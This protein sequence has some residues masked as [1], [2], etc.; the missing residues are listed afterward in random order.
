VREALG[1]VL[2]SLVL[3][4]TL[5]LIAYYNDNSEALQRAMSNSIHYRA[6]STGAIASDSWSSGLTANFEAQELTLVTGLAYVLDPSEPWNVTLV[7]LISGQAVSLPSWYS[8]WSSYSAQSTLPDGGLTAIT[9]NGFTVYSN[10]QPTPN[11][12]LL[13]PGERISVPYMGGFVSV[14]TD[15]GNYWYPYSPAQGYRDSTPAVGGLEGLLLNSSVGPGVPQVGTPKWPV[16]VVPVG[17]ALFEVWSS[18]TIGG[19]GQLPSNLIQGQPSWVGGLPNDTFVTISVTET[20]FHNYN[21]TGVSGSFE[22]VKPIFANVSNM[23]F[24]VHVTNPVTVYLHLSPVNLGSNAHGEINTKDGGVR[25]EIPRSQDFTPQV[26]YEAGVDEL[27]FDVGDNYPPPIAISPI[28]FQYSRFDGV[29]YNWRA[30]YQQE[31][32]ND[33]YVSPALVLGWPSPP[34]WVYYFPPPPTLWGFQFFGFVYLQAGGYGEFGIPEYA[35]AV[36]VGVIVIPVLFGT[37]VVPVVSPVAYFRLVLFNLNVPYSYTYNEVTFRDGVVGSELNAEF[38]AGTPLMS[39]AWYAIK[40]QGGGSGGGFVFYTTYLQRLEEDYVSH[41]SPPSPPS[42]Y[43]DLVTALPPPWHMGN[44]TQFQVPFYAGMD[45]SLSDYLWP[46]DSLRVSSTGGVLLVNASSPYLPHPSLTVVEPGGSEDLIVPYGTRVSVAANT[47]TRNVSYAGAQASGGVRLEDESPVTN[48]EFRDGLVRAQ[49]NGGGELAVE[50]NGSASFNVTVVSSPG[51]FVGIADGGKSY[52]VYLGA[53]L[54]FPANTVLFLQGYPSFPG[55]VFSNWSGEVWTLS[56]GFYRVAELLPN[57]SVEEVS[58]A[59]L[60]EDSPVGAFALIGDT[61]VTAN[62]VDPARNWTVVGVNVRSPGGGVLYSTTFNGGPAA[63]TSQFNFS[64]GYYPYQEYSDSFSSLLPPTTGLTVGLGPSSMQVTVLG[65]GVNGTFGGEAGAILESYSYLGGKGNFIYGSSSA[66]MGYVL[67][68][69]PGEW[70]VV[71]GQAGVPAFSYAYGYGISRYLNLPGEVQRDLGQY[72]A[73]EASA[74][75]F[76]GDLIASS[77]RGENEVASHYLGSLLLSEV[78]YSWVYAGYGSGNTQ[79]DPVVLDWELGMGLLVTLSSA[80]WGIASDLI[81][82]QWDV[83]NPW[84]SNWS[85]ALLTSMSAQRYYAELTLNVYASVEDFDLISALLNSTSSNYGVPAPVVKSL[86]LEKSNGI[87]V[88]LPSYGSAFAWQGK[89]V[90]SGMVMAYYWLTDWL[91]SAGYPSLSSGAGGLASYG[92]V[93]ANL[94]L[95]NSI[96]AGAQSAGLMWSVSTSYYYTPGLA[97]TWFQGADY[98]P[99]S[100]SSAPLYIQV[101]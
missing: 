52:Y 20:G 83:V 36:A 75:G 64:L 60:P 79:L 74:H 98:S 92:D 28:P 54:Q 82:Y 4:A 50:F 24:D 95:V 31:W 49:V 73:Y 17:P 14:M 26:L 53:T 78:A 3:T 97:L 86:L 81:G 69:R 44:V 85:D 16:A 66:V 11:G 57:G 15:G 6:K 76:L 88:D 46:L 12:V 87:T 47:F 101:S 68:T 93:T 59:A 94:E 42:S 99:S 30:F 41:V 1:L 80:N 91:E 96:L 55:A 22:T 67:S 71:G 33:P 39:S 100:P 2:L 70:Y 62:F 23:S 27:D 48:G 38:A 35:V 51:G 61:W 45:Q 43:Q 25:L 63:S 65:Q 34:P 77:L 19:P 5:G 37:I 89:E 9:I 8:A 21:F 29:G 72:T 40:V 84:V 32:S 7:P 18:Y 58:P 90:D 10:G 56:K 13:S